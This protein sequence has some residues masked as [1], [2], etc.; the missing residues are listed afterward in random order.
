MSPPSRSAKSASRGWRGRDERGQK[1]EAARK[2]GARGVLRSHWNTHGRLHQPRKGFPLSSLDAARGDIRGAGGNWVVR[3]HRA[4]SEQV[5]TVGVAQIHRGRLARRCCKWRG[6][7]VFCT[8]G[9]DRGSA[10]RRRWAKI[11]LSHRFFFAQSRSRRYTGR[12]R[13][14][15]L[16]VAIGSLRPRGLSLPWICYTKATSSSSPRTGLRAPGSVVSAA[17]LPPPPQQ[18]A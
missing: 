12:K 13:S 16:S 1:G 18:L 5:L 9:P 2:A 15:P 3:R 8:Q 11:A 17:P 7:E 4:P 14:L 10:R 6:G